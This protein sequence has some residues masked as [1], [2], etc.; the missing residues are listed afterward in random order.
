[1]RR[2]FMKIICIT[3]AMLICLVISA[4]LM[5]CMAEPNNAPSTTD[6]LIEAYYDQTITTDNPLELAEGYVLQINH[7]NI[8]GIKVYLDLLK[9]GKVVDSKIVSPSKDNPTEEDKIYRYKKD[10]GNS[11]NVTLIEIHFKNSF[12]GSDRGLG[13]ISSVMQISEKPN[14]VGK[15]DE[16]VERPAPES[17]L[18]SIRARLGHPA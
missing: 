11:K 18:E 12:R 4:I 8:D 10:I 5:P 2:N 16:P 3:Q 1:M 14:N 13:T 15:I 9:N 7:I 17:L 6:T